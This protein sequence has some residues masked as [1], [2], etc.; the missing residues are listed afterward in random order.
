MS[1]DLEQNKDNA[2]N[3]SVNVSEDEEADGH[4]EIQDPDN[5]EKMESFDIQNGILE[6]VSESYEEG[7]I[8]EKFNFKNGELDGVSETFNA[9]KTTSTRSNY[10]NGQKNGITEIFDEAGNLSLRQSYQNDKLNG[11]TKIFDQ[12][13]LIARMTYKNSELNGFCTYYSQSGL[14]SLRFIYSNNKRQGGAEIYDDKGNICRIDQYKDDLLHGVSQE[15]T[16]EG[17]VIATYSYVQGVMDGETV[18]YDLDGE[19]EV[20]TSYQNGRVIK[21]DNKVE[22]K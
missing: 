15:I 14:P 6:G 7:Q 8:A 16:S 18:T 22:P 2:E 5:N 19:V 11:E 13:C 20:V 9:D 3:K 10:K 4:Y 21:I 12:G 17:R 1:T